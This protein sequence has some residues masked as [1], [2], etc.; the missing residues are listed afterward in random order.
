MQYKGLQRVQSVTNESVL[1]M[2]NLNKTDCTQSLKRWKFRKSSS[3]CFIFLMC[4][5]VHSVTDLQVSWKG[6][7]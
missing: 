5:F 2:Y 3:K 4:S 1:F 6:H 7:E